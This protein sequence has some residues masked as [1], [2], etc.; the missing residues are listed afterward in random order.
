M[1]VLVTSIYSVLGLQLDFKKDGGRFIATFSKDG[2]GHVIPLVWVVHDV[3]DWKVREI[4]V[5][6]PDA[7]ARAPL[8]QSLF[9]A[10]RMTLPGSAPKSLLRA[11]AEDAFIGLT[12]PDMTRLAQRFGVPSEGRRPSLGAELVRMLVEWQCPDL[13]EE[14][15]AEIVAKRAAKG[16]AV[17]AT[18]LTPE[19]CQVLGNEGSSA[20][21]D[22]GKH[23]KSRAES[24]AKDLSQEP[25]TLAPV[26]A[27]IGASSSSSSAPAARV[28]ALATSARAGWRALPELPVQAWTQPMA[29]ALLPAVVGCTIAIHKN[30]SWMV[31][32]PPRPHPPKS[33]SV[34]FAPGETSSS[35]EALRECLAWAWR[36]HKELH[37]GDSCRYDLEAIA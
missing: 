22:E 16:R 21:D 31:K 18:A 2:S 36:V 8:G 35:T 14:A 25:K 29:K 32:Y 33:H 24:Y 17:F 3:S 20:M 37:P 13:S 12:V 4:R 34:A 5:I 6:A 11:A 28:E 10:F 1:L 7:P 23:I 9:T 27:G 19:N 15:V 30:S 26:Q